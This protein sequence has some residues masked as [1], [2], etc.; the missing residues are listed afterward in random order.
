MAPR[1]AVPE[2]GNSID[3]LPHGERDLPGSEMVLCFSLVVSQ[4]Y[5]NLIT[6]SNEILFKIGP[7]YW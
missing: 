3:E 1:E 2:L 7:D 6:N 4:T 5:H